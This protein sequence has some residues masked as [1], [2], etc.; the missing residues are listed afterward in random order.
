M[1]DDV[2]VVGGKME[3]RGKEE[4]TNKLL[5]KHTS[6]NLNPIRPFHR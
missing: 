3:R 2:Y 4:K 1:V 5:I 6:N